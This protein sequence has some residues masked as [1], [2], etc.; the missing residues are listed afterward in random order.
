MKRTFDYVNHMEP[1]GPVVDRAVLQLIATVTF[2]GADFAIQD[3]GVCRMNPELA[4]RVSQLATDRVA[5][6]LSTRWVHSRSPHCCHSKPP[7]RAVSGSRV[8]LDS[9]Q[10]AN[11]SRGLVGQKCQLALRP[12]VRGLKVV[13]YA[14][15]G[16][17][18]IRRMVGWLSSALLTKSA[19]S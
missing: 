2:T 8:R 18:F 10:Q 3:D 17:L 11:K 15:G 13:A 9:R 1:M 6:L 14:L 4:R 5:H 7:D 19:T 12:T 16:P